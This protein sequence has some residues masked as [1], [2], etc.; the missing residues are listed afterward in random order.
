MTSFISRGLC[1]AALALAATG[2]QAQ[3]DS[4][5]RVAANTAWSVFVEDSPKECWAVSAPKESVNTQNGRPVSVNRGAI[6][7]MVSWRPEQSIAGEVY[8]T[9]GYP[10]EEGSKVTLTIGGSSFDLFTQGEDSWPATGSDDARIIEAM[11]RGAD[12]VVVGMSKRGT[13]TEDTF[14]LL[15]FTAA[16]EEAAR[17]CGS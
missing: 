11:K 4:T 15:G 7:M 5:N 10:F 9:G 14:S 1:L 16:V 12:A 8:F 3:D 13:R 6:L 17:Q 2:A